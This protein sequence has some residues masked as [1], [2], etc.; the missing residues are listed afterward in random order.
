M[1]LHP[2]TEQI[3]LG[4]LTCQHDSVERKAL[5]TRLEPR[6]LLVL[7]T[8][9]A[10]I[11]VLN[12]YLQII[13]EWISEI[14][15][16]L[17]LALPNRLT[18]LG[19]VLGETQACTTCILARWA[20]CFRS[21]KYQRGS[22]STS[23]P[24]QF[25]CSLNQGAVI[26]WASGPL[27]DWITAPFIFPPTRSATRWASWSAPLPLLLLLNGVLWESLGGG[28]PPAADAVTTLGDALPRYLPMWISRRNA[29]S[30]GSSWA[31]PFRS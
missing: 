22:G 7:Q 16:E 28:P 27:S 9:D 25:S 30:A 3:V 8:V 20:F 19:Y 14:L 18:S 13:I 31:T 4:A 1:P 21:V 29:M 5:H 17:E 23:T 6:G 24:I 26:K 10:H 12:G 15:L 11:L 2:Q